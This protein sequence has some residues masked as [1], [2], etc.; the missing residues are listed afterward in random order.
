M[1]FNFTSDNES[2]AI[3]EFSF[4]DSRELIAEL[5]RATRDTSQSALYEFV[6]LVWQILDLHE[7]NGGDRE[8]A[9]FIGASLQEIRT[10]VGADQS[11]SD[12]ME[13]LRARAD[14]PLG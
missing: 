14:R 4:D 10:V 5:Q 8:T 12:L 1:D 3:D 6:S 2:E 7:Q 9:E 11:S 13:T